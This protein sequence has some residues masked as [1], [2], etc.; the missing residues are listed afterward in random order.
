MDLFEATL[1]GD[2]VL[3][4]EEKDKRRLT[5]RLVREYVI[6]CHK[7][8]LINSEDYIKLY[9]FMTD[10]LY[11]NERGEPCVYVVND[12]EYDEAVKKRISKARIVD[13][14]DCCEKLK[15]SHHYFDWTELEGYI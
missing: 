1:V 13:L 3:E 12:R 4:Y 14:R 7:Y 11:R 5:T 2:V 6:F 15:A 9:M 8:K 10:T